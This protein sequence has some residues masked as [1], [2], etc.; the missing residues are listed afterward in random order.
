MEEGIE[1][2]N[3]SEWNEVQIQVW[4]LKVV[5]GQVAPVGPVEGTRI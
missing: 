2:H 4:F 3:K 1:I 5:G